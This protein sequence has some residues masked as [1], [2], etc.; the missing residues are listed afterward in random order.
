MR[1]E[2]QSYKFDTR[3]DFITESNQNVISKDNR[4]VLALINHAVNYLDSYNIQEYENIIDVFKNYGFKANQIID[5]ILEFKDYLIDLD[6]T[7]KPKLSWLNSRSLKKVK[8]SGKNIV[9]NRLAHEYSTQLIEFTVT[10]LQKSDQFNSC[11]DLIIKNLT[12]KID[13]MKKS[14]NDSCTAASILVKMPD[15]NLSQNVNPLEPKNE[16]E[17][18]FRMY[19]ED[20]NDDINDENDGFFAELGA[21]NEFHFLFN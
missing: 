17:M 14:A 12:L 10:F 16:V 18:D 19:N 20:F 6:K 2:N 21:S 9:L 7:L 1:K 4:Y 8:F 13:S 11:I 3:E 5:F 15:L